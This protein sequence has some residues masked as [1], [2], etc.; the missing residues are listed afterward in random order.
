MLADTRK[1]PLQ[2]NGMS[3][4]LRSSS[5]MGQTTAS[6]SHGQRFVRFLSCPAGV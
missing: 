3:Q 5:F 2:T 6:L 1:L 4:E